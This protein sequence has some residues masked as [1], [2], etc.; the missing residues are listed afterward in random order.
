MQLKDLTAGD[1]V[2]KWFNLTA[3]NPAVKSETPSLRIN[4]EYLHEIILP[5]REYHSLKEVMK[6]CL[7]SK[8]N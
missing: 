5:A 6:K 8:N 2:D 7:L 1:R 4:V 3:V